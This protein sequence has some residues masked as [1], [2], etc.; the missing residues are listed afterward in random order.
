MVRV[1]NLVFLNIQMI[2]GN[3]PALFRFMGKFADQIKEL[4]IWDKCKAQPAIGEGVLNSRFELIVVLGDTPITRAFNNPS[5]ERGTLDNLFS[6]PAKQSSDSNHGASF[7]LGLVSKLLQAFGRKD[8][9]VFDPFLGTGTT[10]I[11][12]YNDGF[13]F[14]GTEINKDYYDKALNRIDM[15]TRQLSLI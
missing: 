3:K 15:E 2:T 4:I 5:F 14:I 11:A 8:D 6:I 12:A 1:S 9:I 10:A 7:P 13:E